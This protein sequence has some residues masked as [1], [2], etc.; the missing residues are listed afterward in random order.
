[1][2]AELSILGLLYEE[3][4]YGYDIFKKISESSGGVNDL[5]QASVYYHLK[6]IEKKGFV[7]KKGVEKN[8]NN[9]ERYPFQITPEGK[10]YFKCELRRYF[11][12]S[13]FHFDVDLM[14][15]FVNTLD[16]EGKKSFI[17][18]RVE[19]LSLKLKEVREDIEKAKK[20][21]WDISVYS[22]LESHLKAELAW[23]K[24]I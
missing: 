2:R 13:R 7:I 1:M 12:I 8:G 20:A 4:L 14:L 9:L 24:T 3:N 11:E 18:D 22:Y 10:K 15:V 19:S 6:R 23:I 5:K 16:E 17:E 21:S